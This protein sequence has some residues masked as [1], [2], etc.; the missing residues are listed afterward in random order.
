MPTFREI[1]GALH[2][3][4]K[5]RVDVDAAVLHSTERLKLLALEQE[6]VLRTA[7]RDSQ[8]YRALL[9]R[10]AKYEDEL[11]A[12]RARLAAAS[13]DEGRFLRDFEPFT[14][15]RRQLNSLSDDFP[16]LLFPVRLET[17]FRTVA[18]RGGGT[19]HQLWV[20]IFPDDCSIDSFDDTLSE[21]E[22]KKARNYWNNRWKTGTAGSEALEDYVREADRGTWRELMGAFN[23]G[24]AYWIRQHYVPVNAGEMPVRNHEDEKI[25]VIPTADPPDQAT[26]DALKVYWAAVYHAGGDAPQTDAAFATLVATLRIAGEAALVLVEGY[27]PDSFKPEV[28]AAGPL[29]P[30]QV[31]FL[32]FPPSDDVDT[33]LAAW[34]RAAR[35]TTLPERFVLLGFQADRTVPVINE[36]GALI[37]DPLIVGPDAGMDINA[38]LKSIHGAAFDTFSDD[39]KAERY[40]D[41]LA[42]ESE[43]KW[44][45][46]FD[47]AVRIGM[48]FKVDI[49]A[50]IHAQ[51]LDRLFVL[52]VRLSASEMV[53]QGALEELLAHHHFGDSG[54][55]ILPQGTPTNNTEDSR[56]GYSDTE[57]PDEAYDNYH[58]AEA[59]EDATDATLKRDGR[60]LA[61]LLGISVEQSSLNLVP[62]YYLKDQRESRAMNTALWNATLG[63]FMESMLTPV[64]TE[65][66]RDFTRGFLIN[67]VSGRGRLPV[68][69]I[70]DQPYGILP[71]TTFTSMPW[72][73]Q[74]DIPVPRTLRPYRRGLRG[75]HSVLQRMYEDWSSKLDSIAY[76]GKQ[77]NV[78]AHKILL[79][80]LGLH[81]NS[82]E[83]DQRYAESFEHHYNWL[84]AKGA[85]A[86]AQLRE[87]RYR[88]SAMDLLS[89]LGYVHDQQ[90]NPEIPILEKF[91]LTK[92]HDVVKPLI[93]DRELSE[94]DT[95][96][97]YTDLEQN[98]IEW[99]IEHAKNDHRNIRD[100]KGFTDNKPPY[101]LLYDM[102]RHALN[103]Q[104]AGTALNLYRGAEILNEAQANAL[105]MDTEF[106]GVRAQ[107]V[108]LES[109][110]DLIYQSDQR[111]AEGGAMLVDHISSLV[112]GNVVNSQTR[113]LHELID[114]LDLLKDAPTAR[115]ER[116]FI[117]HLDLCTYRLDAWLLGLVDAQ[118]HEM[119]YLRKTTEEGPREGIYLGAFGWLEHLKPDD[120]TLN[121]AQLSPELESIFD[122]D[123]VRQP[124][125]DDA[126]AGYVHA[127]SINHALTAAVLR[128]AY[129]SNASKDAAEPYK[130]NLSSERVRSA[131]AIVEGMQQ[132]QSL[133]ALLGYRLERGLHDN[134]AHELDIFIYELRKVF[135]L[136]SNRLRFTQIKR[137]KPARTPADAERDQE[138]EDEFSEAAAVTKIEARNVLDALSLLD[139]IRK[140]KKETYP[141][142]FAIGDG[143]DRLRDAT[144]GEQD[145]INAEVR[146]LMNI[147]D[148][149]ADLAM[150]ESVHQV[151][152]GNYDRAAGALDAY[153]KGQYPQMPDVIR[154]TGSGVSLTHRF[155]IHL[156]AGVAPMATDPARARTE[157]AI[158]RWIEDLLPSD[159]TTI[160]CLV[161]YTI[162]NYDEAIPDPVVTK[163]V[164]MADLG[165]FPID[166]LYMINVE[167]DKG[168]TALDD[169][170]FEFVYS[171]DTPRADVDIAIRYAHTFDPSD[172]I[173]SFFEVMPLIESLRAL[174][175]S[176]RAL[177][178]ADLAVP[179]EGR[180]SQN[181]SATI[182]AARVTDAHDDV[183]DI[184]ADL[185]SDVITPLSLL[186]DDEDFDVTLGNKAALMAQADVRLDRFITHLSALSRFGIPQAGFGFVYDRRRTIHAAVCWK[187]VEYRTRLRER[188]SQYEMRINVDLL[189][190][191]T[192]E[193]RYEI[194][195]SAERLISTVIAVPAP[196]IPLYVAD[197]S[198]K[199]SD[200]DDKLDEFDA[201][202]A[203][204]FPSFQDLLDGVGT[205]TTNL[206]NFDP[207]PLEVQEEERQ[208]VVLV[209]DLYTQARDT[210]ATVRKAMDEVRTIIDDA[211]A[212]ANAADRV[213]LLADAARRIFGAEFL[214]VPEFTMSA[215]QGS[216]LQQCFNDRAQLLDFQI[217][218]QSTDFPI[219][220]WLYSVARVREKVAAW[221][222]LVMLAEGVRERPPLDLTPLQLPYVENDHWLGLAY[223][224]DLE[225]A[226][227]RLLYTA[228]LP[229][230]I[231]AGP[232]CGLLVDEWTEVIP[233]KKETTGLTF[234]YDRP[235]SEPPQ[236][237][238]LMTPPAFT[239]AW[240]WSD[241][242]R[243]MH[244]TL[245]LARLRAI[246][247]D[248]IDKTRYAQ[249]LPATVA[250][251]TARPVT[252][253][254]NYAMPAAQVFHYTDDGNA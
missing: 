132:G 171:D 207:L 214:I 151:V 60:W 2:A 244:E 12:D 162:P 208:V 29:P 193:E 164:S 49:S 126:N 250:A 38:V 229:T 166:L 120:R 173:L 106:I 92:E 123:G 43:T 159:L 81:A 170:V 115:L 51:G 247:P 105:R 231:A 168:L 140:S 119:R 215:E 141:F 139:H 184:L 192:D 28:R 44:L 40:V 158:N 205:L 37:P 254:I 14:D 35:V 20:R 57:D 129:I 232:Q 153:S 45:F 91:F 243:V 210:I 113:N 211:A 87:W 239:G 77:G 252:M 78:D 213:G 1:Q 70:G 224:E 48:G 178:P 201:F 85:E 182:D 136:I 134:T 96:R 142:G 122:P 66:Q 150:A 59:P 218:V 204:A 186:I 56:S 72:L 31:V 58:P 237:M 199:K 145:A 84:I 187:V 32:I 53:G 62:G 61:E 17:R 102:L 200:F 4:R 79:Q 241:A 152:Q 203:T 175:I 143:P 50:E 63:Y 111:I 3:A 189:A 39:E 27:R 114:A 127:P 11:A 196:A 226:N 190:A 121:P 198:T 185:E 68:I 16:I 93:D 108:G 133:G 180:Q 248:H 179:N 25:L 41:Y 97:P 22:L 233:A 160:A 221:E 253:A 86:L 116:A 89:D 154:S 33:K 80:A 75:L 197:L 130:V 147:R 225:I 251:T 223:P 227:D 100:Q 73:E 181:A 124:M 194:L 236:T 137:E 83:F 46:D 246:E 104:F 235:N 110:W 74:D 174:V 10:K 34:S 54:L 228:Y 149:V 172:D 103:L 8:S 30:V 135:P 112:R 26:Q 157:P 146:R 24:R 65:W 206:G 202:I 107:P 6:Q 216:E 230:F 36:L 82:V 234:H 94:T 212:S 21:T 19:P 220:D 67:H 163:V 7:G 161:E 217:H 249:F 156:P 209:E 5:H 188:Q 98:Y 238:L 18:P 128:N 176:S 183:L 99:L 144:P 242:V 155:G 52:G 177:L 101:A 109:K 69:R 90:L 169:H 64:F 118:L 148:A 13:A 117:E 71:A 131:L 125:V 138:E 240:Q 55:S 15:P 245:D 76:I 42:G 191:T 95:I 23:A 222:T 219:D 165:L 9:Q 195:E 88:E 47:E 167:T